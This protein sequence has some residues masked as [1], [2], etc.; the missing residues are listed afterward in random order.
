MEGMIQSYL[1]LVNPY[2]MF[3]PRPAC[4]ASTLGLGTQELNTVPPLGGVLTSQDTGDKNCSA[5]GAEDC[6]QGK[7]GPGS[8]VSDKV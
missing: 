2:L 5:E 8:Q 7:G 6:A 4:W 1:V 3:G